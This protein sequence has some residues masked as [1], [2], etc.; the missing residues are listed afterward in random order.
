LEEDVAAGGH[1]SEVAGVACCYGVEADD[2]RGDGFT[3]DG[4]EEGLVAIDASMS[5]QYREG[6]SAER[7]SAISDYVTLWLFGAA[8]KKPQRE[9]MSFASIRAI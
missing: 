5:G 3:G 2:H 4:R 6:G 9:S 8:N 1:D 7:L